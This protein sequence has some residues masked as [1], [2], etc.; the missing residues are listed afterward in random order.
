[1]RKL[2]KWTLIAMAGAGVIVGFLIVIFIVDMTPD[3]G[4][5]EE[6]K[7]KASAY[8]DAHFSGQ[9]EMYDTLYD[10]MGN[11]NG[12][13]YAAKVRNTTNGVDFTV[14]EDAASGEMVDTYAVNYFEDEL[15]D[16]IMED[17]EKRFIE[18]E[19][20]MVSYADPAVTDKYIGETDLPAIQELDAAPSVSIWVNRER[21]PAD[22]RSVDELLDILKNDLKLPHAQVMVQYQAEEEEGILTKEY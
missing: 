5:E 11:F 12:F 1:M 2:G 3:A 4:K 18:I 21:K 8:L 10:N 16:L 13:D 9:M 6:V 20:V 15:S 14:Y 19:M 22:E 7:E 17:V